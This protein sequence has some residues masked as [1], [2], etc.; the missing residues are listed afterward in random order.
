MK[1]LLFV[2]I[3]FTS[4]LSF[5]SR[6]AFQ[7]GLGMA[8]GIFHLNL[9]VDFQKKASHSFGGYLVY[10]AGKAFD[11]SN[12]SNARRGSFWSLGGDMKVFFGPKNWRLYVAPGVGLLSYENTA[13]TE[14]QM[15]LGTLFKVGALYRISKDMFIGLEQMF[16]H[17]WFNSNADGGTYDLANIAFRIR[18]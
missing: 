11:I 1:T 3:L 7:G 15:T 8:N 5:G 6:M 2:S 9:D 10:G 4:S 12:Q 18:F 13:M 14:S 17:N 16:I